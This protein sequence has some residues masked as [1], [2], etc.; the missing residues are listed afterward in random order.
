LYLT[1]AAQESE[2]DRFRGH[3]VDLERFH[4]PL[5][6]LL[7]LIRKDQIEIWEIE[8]S[9]ITRQYLAYLES[10]RSLNIEV[11]GDFLVMAAT[12]MRIKSQNLLPRPSFLPAEEDGEEPLTRDGLIARLVEYKR[13][14]EAAR[15]MAQL[16]AA[17][18][19]MHP[20]GGVAVLGPKQLLPLREPKLI[21]LAEYFR[22]LLDRAEPKAG[23]E[24]HLEEVKLEEQMDWVRE[25]LAR[26][27]ELEFLPAIGRAGL[28]FRR[29]LRRPWMR[30][31]ICVTFL[32][33]L[34]LARLQQLHLWQERSLEELWVLS[35]P[36][37]AVAAGEESPEFAWEPEELPP[38]PDRAGEAGV[39]WTGLEGNEAWSETDDPIVER[40]FGD[41]P[42]RAGIPELDKEDP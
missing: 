42:L 22:E 1:H 4:G 10:L 31:E 14:R 13:Y 8:I 6:L 24:I 30:L 41:D 17:Q 16:E 2:A 40:S 33:V 15:A 25:S 39:E 37:D 29:L 36:P 28:S 3:P 19:R 27:E 9:R 26:E 32:A 34:E 38:D 12:L 5:D 20:V 35:R 23:H 21:D 11:A 18:S 7:H